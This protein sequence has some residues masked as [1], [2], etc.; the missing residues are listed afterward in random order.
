[1]IILAVFQ[2]YQCAAPSAVRKA[3]A[4]D[5][6][7]GIVREEFIFEKASDQAFQDTVKLI[8]QEMSGEDVSLKVILAEGEKK[9]QPEAKPARK[10][11]KPT[12]Q[13]PVIQKAISLFDVKGTDIQVIEDKG[14]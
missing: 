2:C 11:T 8:A 6:R 1:M 12:E 4:P 13:A 3:A 5:F 7:T 9:Q 14:D 10:I